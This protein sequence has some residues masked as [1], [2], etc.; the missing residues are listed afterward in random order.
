[1]ARFGLRLVNRKWAGA[2]IA[3]AAALLLAAGSARAD[4]Q[5]KVGKGGVALIFNIV[6][7]GKQVGIFKQFG[8]DV[9]GVQFDG[10]APLE[11]A[12]TA[13][14]LDIGLA[15]GT[16][17]G[18]TLKGVPMHAVAEL[19]GA[20]YDFV[21]GVKP[22]SPLKTADDLKGKKVSVTSTGS[23]TWWL[24]HQLAT[25]KGW[26]ADAITTVP[27][28]STAA[29]F[30]AMGH[31]DVDAQTTTPE[32]AFNYVENGQMR[33][34]VFYGDE[35]KQFISHTILA[36]DTLLAKKP[37]VVRR[38]LQGWFTTIKWVKDPA[39]HDQTAKIIADVMNISPS[40]AS[41]A[42]D[43][44]VKGL[45]DDGAFDPVSVDMVRNSLPAFGVLDSV[46]PVKGLYDDQYVPVKL[47]K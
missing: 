25:Q 3:A 41:K 14:D 46:P 32:T 18:F 4:D 26:G 7:V 42:L 21:V 31:G 8:I 20:P 12:M 44:D 30:A 29:Q 36:S 33:V 37:D 28:G 45:S 16:S 13:G 27:L 2:G 22:D 40:A 5:I 39:H 6:E 9:T 38:F 34:L 24:A 35:I 43:I 10:E 1:M 47:A 11:K 23:L 15:A 19:S 17:M